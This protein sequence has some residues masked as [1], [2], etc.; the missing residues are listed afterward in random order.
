MEFTLPMAESHG[1]QTGISRRW[2]IWPPSITHWKEMNYTVEVPAFLQ[3]LWKTLENRFRSKGLF[4][5]CLKDCAISC[6]SHS[7]DVVDFVL[8]KMARLDDCLRLF[9]DYE[10]LSLQKVCSTE[11][12]NENKSCL[13]SRMTVTE[14]Y[15][16]LM[17]AWLNNLEWDNE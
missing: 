5:R 12:L 8:V 10:E 11:G 16:C 13:F 17:A 3:G 14:I 6:V 7:T 2:F 9:R 15:Y 1:R 4:C